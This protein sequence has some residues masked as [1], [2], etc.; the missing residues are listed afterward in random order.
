MRFPAIDET[1]WGR[2]LVWHGRSRPR[3]AY[4]DFRCAG[5]LFRWSVA[6]IAL[7]AALLPYSAAQR[8]A[9]GAHAAAPAHAATPHFRAPA[10]NFAFGRNGHGFGPP[11][12]RSSPPHAS[13]P[14]PFFGDSF[15]P[16]DIYSTGYPVAS[17][18]PAY[19][20]QALSQMTGPGAASMGPALR[21]GPALGPLNNQ[22]SS[23]DPLLIELQN[24]RYVRVN[25]PALN[26]DPR[27]QNVAPNGTEANSA[28]P[29][30]IAK[31]SPEPLPPA[32]L[33]FRDG[34]REEVR[35]YTIADG[36]LY[37]RGDYYTDGYWNK[38]IDL[39]KLNVPETL[40]ANASRNV[41][42]VLPSSPNEVITRP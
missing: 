21:L 8:A 42:F 15:D 25:S 29:P 20:L 27:L 16:G 30:Q 39:A 11:L 12:R 17:E 23:S 14:F 3:S 38:K 19:L 35:D 7:L 36:T 9:S 10:G 4:R 32:V 40:E 37:A 18:P 24:G 31:A 28:H 2:P 5:N 26:D 22:S 34:H 6:L 41:K 1:K 33:I 13:L